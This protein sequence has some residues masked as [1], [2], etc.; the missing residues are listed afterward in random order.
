MGALILTLLLLLALAGTS[1][2]VL[3][4]SNDPN[5]AAPPDDP[6]WNHVG[7]R[8]GTTNSGA[9][10]NGL[11]LIYLGN[12]WV[13]TAHH[14]GEA[15]LLLGGE[16]WP[17]VQNSGVRFTNPDGSPADLMAY[18]ITANPS[19]PNLPLLE[20]RADP[21]AVGDDV[22]LIGRGRNRGAATTW[23]QPPLR[24]GW[25]WGPGASM[26]W[27]TNRV[28]S[29]LDESVV[30][31]RAFASD[32]T[33]PGEP[34]FTTHEAH[35]VVGDSGGAAFAKNGSDWELAGVLFGTFQHTGQDPQ[36]SLDGNLHF[37]SDLSYFR[38]QIIATVRPECSDEID[39]DGDSL[40]DFPADPDC[41]SAEDDEELEVALLPIGGPALASLVAVLL[42]GGSWPL[43]RWQRRR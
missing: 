36:S 43:L 33:K 41:D 18:Q 16:T 11:T 21:L 25:L 38:S 37:A 17:R 6:G 39:N 2:A 26:R 5:D 12:G 4:A 13:L 10:A 14:V 31:T 24:E 8:T 19:L 28:E 15:D 40:T 34:D 7:T 1:S 9:P 30:G 29:L 20:I 42:V 3:I 27:G 22:T 32:F 35:A 23:L